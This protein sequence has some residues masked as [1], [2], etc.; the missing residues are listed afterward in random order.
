LQN[1]TQAKQAIL[2]TK[3]NNQISSIYEARSQALP[4]DAL[5]FIQKP[6]EQVLQLP[7]ATKQQWVESVEVAMA[8]K[9]RHGY[10]NHLS[11]QHFMAMWVIYK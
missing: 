6:K 7:L 4:Q 5:T 8:C 2:K 1:S 3:I 9:K 10:G 11:E